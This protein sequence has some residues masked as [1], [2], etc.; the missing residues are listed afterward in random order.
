[1]S[2]LT[3]AEKVA[4]YIRLRDYKQQAEKSFSESMQRVYQGMEKLEN[5]MLQDL[6][7][8]GVD[9]MAGPSGT[10]YRNTQMS[11]TVENRDDFMQHVKAHN[12]WEALDVKANKTFVRSYMDETQETFPGVKVTLRHTVGVR[13]S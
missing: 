9:S 5:E 12:L 1:M 6:Q 2:K 7:A 11:A 8:A 3:P 10:V 13:R 4:A